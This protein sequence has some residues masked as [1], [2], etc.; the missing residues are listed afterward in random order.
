MVSTSL[1]Y[2]DTHL[3]TT[4]WTANKHPDQS[5]HQSSVDDLLLGPE[6]QSKLVW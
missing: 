1:T 3:V 6:L 4:T 2:G 5:Q